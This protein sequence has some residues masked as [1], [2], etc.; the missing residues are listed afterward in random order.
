MFDKISHGDAPSYLCDMLPQ[1]VGDQN[2]YNLH[3]STH[4]ID[5]HF[6]RCECYR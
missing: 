4:K 2:D 3:L 6:T 5:I 1:T